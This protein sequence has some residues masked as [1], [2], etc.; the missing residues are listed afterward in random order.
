MRPRCL[1]LTSLLAACA[2][3]PPPVTTARTPSQL[4]AEAPDTHEDMCPMTVPGAVVASEA[5]DGGTAFVFTTPGDVAELRRRV[6][7]LARLHGQRVLTQT[8]ATL[9]VATD[10]VASGVRLNIR[11]LEASR[12]LEIHD[13][14][15]QAARLLAQGS[16]PA[17]AND[18][19]VAW[20]TEGDDARDRTITSR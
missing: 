15:A 4:L 3:A 12:T 6:R 9:L 11:P 7:T 10:D 13:R 2:S 1:V 5:I 8:R 20:L 16:C 17:V 14:G 18:A 19:L